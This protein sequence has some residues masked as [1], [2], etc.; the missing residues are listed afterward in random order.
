M[1]VFNKPP[2]TTPEH[3]ALLKERGLIIAD[4]A[5]AAHYLEHIGYYRFSGYA[6]RY[7]HPKSP[8]GEHVFIQGATFEQVLESYKFDQD[9]RLLTLSAL[10]KIEVSLKANLCNAM[11]LEH[12]SNWYENVGFFDNADMH[13]DFMTKLKDG[14]ASDIKGGKTLFIKHYTASYRTPELPPCWMV[15]ETLSLGAVSS[16]YKN[17]VVT[18]RKSIEKAYR[19]D[20][21]VLTSWLHALAVIRNS[22]AHHS[23]MWDKKLTVRPRLLK[24]NRELLSSKQGTFYVIAYIVLYLLKAIDPDS[25]WGDKLQELFKKYPGINPSVLGFNHPLAQDPIWN[26]FKAT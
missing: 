17:L 24:K 7:Q 26:W 10:E 15:F 16:L 4:E 23:R 12:G 25:Q 11:C 14:L 22:C 21:V 8:S 20:E 5:R 19:C 6:L 18:N 2:K 3:V 13:T 9:L 1:T